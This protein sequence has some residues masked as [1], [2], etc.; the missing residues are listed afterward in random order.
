MVYLIMYDIRE[1]KVR[2]Q[3]AKYLLRQG[4]YRLQKSVFM[5][6]LSAA[7]YREVRQ[8]LTDI[9]A[10][11]ENSDSMLLLPVDATTLQKLEVIGR[12]LDIAL[13]SGSKSTHFI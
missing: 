6:K 7:T 9:Q 1:T 11:Y 8:N 4:C 13:I 10:M 3:I 2:T 5:G 12:E